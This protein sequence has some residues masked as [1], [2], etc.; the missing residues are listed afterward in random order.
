MQMLIPQLVD[1]LAL[2]YHE[3]RNVRYL[4]K[5][6]YMIIDPKFLSLTVQLANNRIDAWKQIQYLRKKAAIMQTGENTKRVFER[7]FKLSLD[8]LIE[9]YSHPGWKGSQYGGN[10]WLPIALN[11]KGLLD[12]LDSGKIEESYRLINQILDSHHNTGV[13]RD[14]IKELDLKINN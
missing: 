6:K 12:L 3:G 9:L 10:A 2:L 7:Q 5:H 11:A 4:V 14:K 1:V 13:V 8:D